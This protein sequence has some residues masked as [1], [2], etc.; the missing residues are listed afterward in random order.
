MSP[1]DAPVGPYEVTVDCLSGANK[2]EFTYDG[3][4]WL[5]FNPWCKGDLVYMPD[6]DKLDEYVLSDVGKI[7]V[8]PMGS[9]RGRQWVFGQFD[10]SILPSCILMLD[11]VKLG[12]TK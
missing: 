4:L 9:S 3:D 2:T 1:V 11:R 8:G 5:L 10:S 12:H 7:W 6:T